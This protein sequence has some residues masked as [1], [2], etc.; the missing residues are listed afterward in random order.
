MVERRLI[1]FVQKSSFVHCRSCGVDV[2]RTYTACG[3][4]T[5]RR[6]RTV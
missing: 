3:V 6:W 1:G 2:W 5:V 4:S